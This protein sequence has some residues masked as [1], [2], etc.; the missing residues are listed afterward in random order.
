MNVDQIH[1]IMA[2]VF[3]IDLRITHNFSEGLYAKQMLIP[4][5]YVVG[6]HSH[7]FDHLSILAKGRV[8]VKTDALEREYAAPSC[9]EIKK[10]THHMITALEESVWFCVHATTVTDPDTV[11]SAL[12]HKG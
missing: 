3:D 11:D 1:D 6:Q 8:I 7:T 12:I 4:A 2:G 10:H 9:I 5:G